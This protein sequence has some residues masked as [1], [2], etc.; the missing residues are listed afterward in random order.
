MC[1]TTERAAILNRIA[2][3]ENLKPITASVFTRA[4]NY[5]LDGAADFD[6][7]EGVEK[8]VIGLKIEKYWLRSFGFPMKMTKQKIERLVREN[9]GQTFVNTL[10]DTEIA[11]IPVDLKHTIGDNWMVPPEAFGHWLLLFKSNLSDN[12]YS[13]G[14]FKADAGHLTLKG[15]QDKKLNISAEGKKHI[16]WIIT[17]EAFDK[18]AC[19][20]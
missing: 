7:L 10:L 15:N 3:L 6:E 16:T 19:A 8:S 4:L 17:D 11:E 20:A 1:I 13:L 18:P 12:T 14:L 5:V 9:P 2:A